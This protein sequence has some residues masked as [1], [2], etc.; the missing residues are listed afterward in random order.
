MIPLLVILSIYYLTMKFD[1]YG[2]QTFNRIKSKTF[3]NLVFDGLFGTWFGDYSWIEATWT[4]NIELIATFFV[5]LIAQTGVFY[6]GRFAIYM[7]VITFIFIIQILGYVKL[8]E[9]HQ[10]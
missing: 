3:F 7:G 6:R 4:L 2:E 8:V 1:F 10:S 9:I 5:L